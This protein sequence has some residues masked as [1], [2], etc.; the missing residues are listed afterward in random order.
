GC[1]DDNG[2]VTLTA[3]DAAPEPVPEAAPT[4]TAVPTPT[5]AQIPGQN[6]RTGTR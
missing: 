6:C 3:P 5:V 4:T 2:G 1:L